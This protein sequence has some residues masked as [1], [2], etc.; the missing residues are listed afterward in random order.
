[1]ICPEFVAR[2]LSGFRTARNGGGRWAGFA[3]AEGWRLVGL[4]ALL[5]GSGLLEEQK[6]LAWL[7]AGMAAGV[8]RRFGWFLH[9]PLFIEAAT[10]GDTGYWSVRPGPRQALLALLRQYRVALVASGGPVILPPMLGEKRLGAVRYEF[11]GGEVR[12]AI[13][14]VPGLTEH[15]IDHMID[16]VYPAHR[17]TRPSKT[18]GG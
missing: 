10:E 9:R 2:D 3:D 11:A 18:R 15:W 12:A 7:N 5:F 17:D 16:D 4:N 13:V 1:V 8:G 6:Q 14:A